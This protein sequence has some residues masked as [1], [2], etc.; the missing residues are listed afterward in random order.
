M[1]QIFN[2]STDYLLKDETDQKLNISPSASVGLCIT[3]EEANAFMDIKASLAGFLSIAVS[4]F[5][6]SPVCL[7]QFGA[8]SEIG[9]MSEASAGGFGTS[10]L[11][12]MIAIGVG[13]CIHYGLKVKQFEYLENENFTLLNG[14][15]DL[16][17]QRKEEFA[18][19]FK[20]GMI[21]ATVICIV[22][23]VPLLLASAFTE[24]EL[25]L[26]SCVNVLLLA[27]A[28]A[29]N[30][31][32]R[33]GTVQESYTKLL[34][35]DDY[36]PENKTVSKKIAFFPPAYWLIV[37]AIYLALSLSSNYWDKTWIIWPIAGILFVAFYLILK[38][39]VE[40]KEH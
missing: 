16:V 39:I 22:G 11:L 30:I 40:R 20:R 15:Y 35:I 25:I 21:I 6:L 31:F 8:F 12:I 10:I 2:V 3:E 18:P 36:T 33:V 27:I 19:I 23:I 38:A 5:V 24:N 9:K 1:S 13:M 17:I 28:V 14:V 29:V 7:I 34:Q 37:T 26:I 4:L 32:V